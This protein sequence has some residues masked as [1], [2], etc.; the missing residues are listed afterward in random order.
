M[1]N[2]RKLTPFNVKKCLTIAIH[3][4]MVIYCTSLQF[5]F[6]YPL[7]LFYDAISTSGYTAEVYNVS[8]NLGGT[9]KYRMPEG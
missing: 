2:E 5:N 7:C 9:S 1:K 6:T 8:K 3:T 4:Q